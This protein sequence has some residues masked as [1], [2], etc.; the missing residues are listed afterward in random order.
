MCG[1]VGIVGLEDR[2]LIRKMLEKISHRGPDDHGLYLDK[3]VSLAHARLSIIDLSEMGR[4]PIH[5]EDDSIQII[6]NGEIYNFEHLKEDLEKKGHRF[7]TNTDTEVIVHLYEEYGDDCVKYLNGMFAFAIWDSTKER[8]FLARDR[9]GIKPLYYYYN[10]ETFIFSSE[11]K[12][13]LEYPLKREVDIQSMNLYFNFLF[14]PGPRTMFKDIKKLMPGHRLTLSKNHLDIRKYWDIGNFVNTKVSEAGIIKKMND[15]FECSV[16]LRLVSERP[17]GIFLSGG[18]DST[19]V[20]KYFS[21]YHDDKIKTFTIGFDVEE[22]REKYN[23]DLRIARKT[24]EVFNTDHREIFLSDEDMLRNFEKVVYHLDEPI[25]N[26]TQL[27]IFHLAENAKKEVTVV[28]SGE[29][30]DELFGGYNSYLTNNYINAYQRIPNTLREKVISP[31]SKVFPERIQNIN[32]TLN[33]PDNET[34]IIALHSDNRDE[35]ENLISNKYYD[36]HHSE[37]YIRSIY[38]TQ[39][40]TVSSSKR[41]FYFDMKTRLVDNFLTS[42]D[43]MTMT[44]ALEDRVPLL[45]H[46]LVEFSFTIPS[47]LKT[48]GNTTKYLLKKMISKDVPKEVIRGKRAFLMPTSK[49][50][51]TR[52]KDMATDYLSENALSKHDFFNADQVIGVLN[53]H[54]NKKKYN[55][56]LISA[57]LTFQIWYKHF[58]IENENT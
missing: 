26:T 23:E 27:A 18:V 34:R 47:S 35:I 39:L 7:Y 25:S 2:L 24:S 57:V 43:K 50:L 56:G 9:I 36:K 49:W 12:A 11:I 5:N 32:K 40:K 33:L 44:F 16:Q 22:Q 58:F 15:M 20:L 41:L 53:D 45:D 46:N 38:S 48:K 1:I 8:L 19:A 30:G 10:G 6:F 4:Q 3:K 54:I 52:M 37:D 31:I 14:V 42:T 29:G 55:M 17:I 21:K 28:L 13:I 51:R